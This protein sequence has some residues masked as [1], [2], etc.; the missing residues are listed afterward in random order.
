MKT[1]TTEQPDVK[2]LADDNTVIPRHADP[3]WHHQHRQHHP[4]QAQ[5]GRTAWREPVRAVADGRQQPGEGGAAHQQ[6]NPHCH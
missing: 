1:E 3:P 5:L 6:S 2:P 4:A